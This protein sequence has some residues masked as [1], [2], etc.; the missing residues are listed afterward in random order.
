MTR[1]ISIRL[2]QVMGLK[3]GKHQVDVGILP[4]ISFH[5][6]QIGKL[7]I[8][9]FANVGYRPQK[10][11][12]GVL[13]DYIKKLCGFG[14][15]NGIEGLHYYQGSRWSYHFHVHVH[16]DEF[17]DKRRFGANL[18]KVTKASHYSFTLFDPLDGLPILSFTE[19]LRSWN[20]R[21]SKN[22]VVQIGLT[23]QKYENKV[24][25]KCCALASVERK[26]LTP[27]LVNCK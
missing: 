2:K 26:N 8:I 17:L 4:H 27:V 25:S 21:M 13:T 7:P 16:Y 15:R 18:P 3:K 22:R 1:I 24:M 19:T 20:S 6:E 23:I 12:I 14:W 10:N 9:S 11:G 5:Y